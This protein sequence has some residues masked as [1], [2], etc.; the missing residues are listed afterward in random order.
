M[1]HGTMRER[2]SVTVRPT[3]VMPRES[4]ASS[5]H[6]TFGGY[7]IVRHANSGVPE[8]ARSIGWPKSETSDFGC[9]R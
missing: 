7:W 2:H 3:I 8:F 6:C 5:T 4:G 9:G 1:M